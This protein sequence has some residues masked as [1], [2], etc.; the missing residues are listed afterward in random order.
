MSS[1]PNHARVIRLETARPSADPPQPPTG[2]PMDCPRRGP[3][4]GRSRAVPYVGPPGPARA[5]GPYSLTRMTVLTSVG[6]GLVQA[7]TASAKASR[8][9]TMLSASILPAASISITLGQ[10]NA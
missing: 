3:R 9:L 10:V 1:V 8:R 5:D 4:V 7:S 6:R 2:P